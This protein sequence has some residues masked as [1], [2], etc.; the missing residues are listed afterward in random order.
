MGK[1]WL[2]NG[3]T[4]GPPFL[5]HNP[6]GVGLVRASFQAPQGSAP[7]YNFKVF[8]PEYVNKYWGEYER[9]LPHSARPPPMR[10]PVRAFWHLHPICKITGYN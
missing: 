7:Q 2:N 3:R 9:G 1:H 4:F 5:N 6:F 10:E 8:R